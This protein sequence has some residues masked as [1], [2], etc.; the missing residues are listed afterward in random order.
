MGNEGLCVHTKGEIDDPDNEPGYQFTKNGTG[1]P[2]VRV[3]SRRHDSAVGGIIY[4]YNKFRSLQ[5]EP[6]QIY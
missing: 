5:C 6:H 4:I 1:S 3:R 2:M